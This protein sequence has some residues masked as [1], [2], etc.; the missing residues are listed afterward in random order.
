MSKKS[1]L[2]QVQ[3]RGEIGFNKNINLWG[4]LT[5]LH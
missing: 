4:K 1:V 5:G 2:L 3:E